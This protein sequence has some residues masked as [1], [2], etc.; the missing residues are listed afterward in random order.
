MT[1]PG[2][3]V[4]VMIR[5][6]AMASESVAAAVAWVGLVESDTVT[7]TELDPA[8]VGVPDI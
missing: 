5:A 6:G 2:S 3:E 7:T 8:D 4:V 1:P